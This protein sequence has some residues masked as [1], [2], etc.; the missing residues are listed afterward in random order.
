MNKL[1]IKDCEKLQKRHKNA[2]GDRYPY[3]GLIQATGA[4]NPPPLP[5]LPDNYVYVHILS[6]GIHVRHINDQDYKNDL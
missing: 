4:I 2:Y 6:W 3:K 5:E 1:T